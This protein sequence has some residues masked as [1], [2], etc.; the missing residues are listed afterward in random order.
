MRLHARATLPVL[1]YVAGAALLAAF[2][3]AIPA[4]AESPPAWMFPNTT[5]SNT[6]APDDGKMKTVPDSKV[7]LS[8]PQIRDF[9]SPPDWFPDEHPAMPSLAGRGV[10]P[11]IFAC[12]Y[13]HL[14]SGNGRPENANIAGLPASY[15][16]RQVEDMKSGAR[17]SSLPQHFPQ[18]L[19]LELA[20]KAA[21][22]PGLAEAAEYFASLK[23]RT[24]VKV[25]EAETIP[26]VD[27]FR[28]VY[29]PAAG[30]GTEPLGNR[31]VELMD[32]F[33]RF[34]NRDA[35]VTYTAYVPP[36][37]L[38][39][40]K[41]LIEG[42][43]NGTAACAT[44]HGEGLKGKDPAPPIAGRSPSYAARQLFDMKHG[45]RNGAGMQVM[46]P[47]VADLTNE[48]I[49]AISAYLATLTP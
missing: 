1:K 41:D 8:V 47:V 14:P 26:K 34:E 19:M 29:V 6:L 20:V 40:G 23:P 31:L 30:G 35:H 46:K 7:T 44:C 48:D 36:G 49:I 3:A 39:R 4:R 18:K 32:D 10:K 11:G 9:Y 28:W 37:S 43:V 27:I 21:T 38:A 42:G 33:E 22:D 25:V 17:T 24:V 15:I 45:A 13:C 12:G 5:G 16:I 2:A